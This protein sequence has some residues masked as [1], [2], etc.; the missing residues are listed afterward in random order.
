MKKKLLLGLCVV[1]I[2]SLFAFSAPSPSKGL[3]VNYHPKSLDCSDPPIMMYEIGLIGV[4]GGSYKYVG[5]LFCYE[6]PN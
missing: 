4:M 3:L 6:V 5:G 1:G 2:S